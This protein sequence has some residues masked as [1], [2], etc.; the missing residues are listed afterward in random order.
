[1]SVLVSTLMLPYWFSTET[2]CWQFRVIS[3]GGAVFGERKIYYS[4]Q[5]AE[6]AGREWIREGS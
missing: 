2:H 6:I 4:A 1:M 3:V 5:A